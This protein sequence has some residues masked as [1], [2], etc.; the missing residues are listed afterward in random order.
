[1]STFADGSFRRR[2]V[3][4]SSCHDLAAR[5]EVSELRTRHEK[6]TQSGETTSKMSAC[7][8]LFVAS[9]GIYSFSHLTLS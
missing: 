2:D 6:L 3:S 9:V 8:R 1:M 7:C 4:S 5:R